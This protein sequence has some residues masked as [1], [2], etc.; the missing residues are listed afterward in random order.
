MAIFLALIAVFETEGYDDLLVAC[1]SGFLFV[2]QAFIGNGFWPYVAE[3]VVTES[4]FSLA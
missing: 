3:A 4:G 1:F 2:Y